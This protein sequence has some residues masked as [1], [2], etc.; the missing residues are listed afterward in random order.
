MPLCEPHILSSLANNTDYH[1]GEFKRWK[2]PDVPDDD[3]LAYK[4]AAC[5]IEAALEPA[6]SREVVAL[7]ARLKLHCRNVPGHT[8]G[9][10]KLIF[11]DYQRDLSEIPSDIL[12]TAVDVWRRS[13][14]WWPAVSDLL[15]I[16]EPL[17][18][19]RRAQLW[20]AEHIA[21]GNAKPKREPWTPPT[22]EE[23]ARV[24]EV[25]AE[26]KANLMA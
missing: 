25:L 7:L 9:Q 17:L 23:K 1:D 26:V 11:E 21:K 10:W 6:E 8:D 16:A 4:A 5:R 22:D 14:P 12:Q 13:E 18:K 19:E 2:C 20:R 15:A 3:R 24:A